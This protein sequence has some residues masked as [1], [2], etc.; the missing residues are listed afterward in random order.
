MEQAIQVQDE[1]IKNHVILFHDKSRKFI[2][3]EKHNKIYEL[4]ANPS[5]KM[6]WLNKQSYSF[7][8]ISKMLPISEFYEQYPDERPPS[9][10]TQNYEDPI[11]DYSD[12]AMSKYEHDERRLEMFIQGLNGYVDGPNYQ[13]T[14][15]P[16]VILKKYQSKLYKLVK[17][18]EL[19][20]T[21]E[22]I[23]KG[24]VPE[25]K[26]DTKE[27]IYREVAHK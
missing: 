24:E 20:E 13:G 27:E 11:P 12:S 8:S 19:R 22:S 7:G 16:N 14:D 9:Y 23:E 2:T 5:I 4:S 15:G 21:K 3:E 10:A 18:R 6:F 26:K 1:G 17:E 25:E